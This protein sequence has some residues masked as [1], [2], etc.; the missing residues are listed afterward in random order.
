MAPKAA[1]A[2]M[3]AGP[4]KN[5]FHQNIFRLARRTLRASLVSLSQT[6]LNF[7]ISFLLIF[8]LYARSTCNLENNYQKA[9]K[10]TKR[11]IPPNGLIG[12][13]LV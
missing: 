5:N 10:S 13:L 3:T 6:L 12:I 4:Q 8:L 11:F 2:P 1:T 7:P 9:V